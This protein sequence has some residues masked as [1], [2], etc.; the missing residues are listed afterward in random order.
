M[1]DILL[2]RR[3]SNFVAPI[4][5]H[6]IRNNFLIT[7][8]QSSLL[9]SFFKNALLA[10]RRIPVS[11]L[12]DFLVCACCCCRCFFFFFVCVCRFVRARFVVG[13]EDP[14]ED[15]QIHSITQLKASINERTFHQAHI[16]KQYPF[17]LIPT[18][19]HPSSYLVSSMSS[20]VHLSV[21]LNGDRVLPL[22]PLATTIDVGTIK[23]IIASEVSGGGAHSR[24][25]LECV[26]N[27]RVARCAVCALYES[28][29]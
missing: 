1:R 2:P 14:N 11:P 27:D 29:F 10:T 23:M 8:N 4:D 25:R 21:L 18:T 12:L 19:P 3:F 28:E 13:L 16:R 17:Q 6:T 22:P 24:Q 9:C 20:L 26:V 7:Q 15:P 5:C